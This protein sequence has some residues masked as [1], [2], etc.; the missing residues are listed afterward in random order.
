MAN[1]PKC[2]LE[3]R[4]DRHSNIL[5]TPN[6]VINIRMVSRTTPKPVDH[7]CQTTL[8]ICHCGCVLVIL[9]AD[10]FGLTVYHHPEWKDVDWETHSNV[11]ERGRKFV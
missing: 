7:D 2:N 3:W 5:R 11:Y 6:E 1:C 8:L 10:E 4:W 9:V